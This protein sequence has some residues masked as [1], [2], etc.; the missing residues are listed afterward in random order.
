MVVFKRKQIVILSLVLMIVVAGYLN[1]SYKQSSISTSD[2]D[3][4]KVG[5][6]IYVDNDKGV[7]EEKKD[8][9]NDG[10]SSNVA[11][12]SKYAE[13]FFAQAK[14][15]REMTRSKDTDALKE[16][17]EDQNASKESK[18]KAHDQ[19]IK[20]LAN[21]EKEMK[22]EQIIKGKG[23]NDSIVL[24]GDDNSIDIYVKAPSLS[25]AQIASIADGASRQAK[26]PMHK[27]VVKNIF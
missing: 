16:I 20:I 22:I 6:A 4:G 18:N 24:F 13:D 9:K 1:Y 19:M 11:K 2:K 3:D 5:E 26:I 23:F 12:A 17:T 21:S 25:A 10:K 27:I 8:D 7:L 15:D 14:L